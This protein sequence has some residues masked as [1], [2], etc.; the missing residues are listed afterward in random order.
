MVYWNKAPKNNKGE[1][2]DLEE[3]INMRKQQKKAK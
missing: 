3:R 1:V 2:K